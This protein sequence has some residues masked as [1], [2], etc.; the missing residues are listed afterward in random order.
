MYVLTDAF[1]DYNW[2]KENNEYR[3]DS[4]G[5]LG[6]PTDLDSVVENRIA[7]DL[8]VLEVMEKN[9]NFF[10]DNIKHYNCYFFDS[11][12]IRLLG[13]PVPV[14]T[15]KQEQ[16]DPSLPLFKFY[17]KRLELV[18]IIDD[19]IDPNNPLHTIIHE[20]TQDYDVAA[21]FHEWQTNPDYQPVAIDLDKYM[22]D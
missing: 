10:H 8:V 13:Q 2:N 22:T 6:E 16:A 14:Y 9:R 4:F 18:E 3:F 12:V 17:Y 11:H 19:I 1:I 20:A 15:V 21:L 7:P 5:N